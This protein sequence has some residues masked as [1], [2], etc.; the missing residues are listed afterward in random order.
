MNLSASK[1][2]IAVCLAVSAGPSF[3]QIASE[4]VS[5]E[6]EIVITAPRLSGLVVTDIPPVLELDAT[7]VESYG[8]SSITE[9]L[10][11]LGPQTGGG[12]GRGSGGPIVLLNGKRIS[13]FS[14]IRDLPPEAIERVQ[15][16][17]EEVA[18]QFGA[19][20]D[21]RVVNFILKDNFAALTGEIEQGA[22][23]AGGRRETEVESTFVRIGKLGRT[24]LNATYIDNAGLLESARGI[25][26]RPGGLSNGGDFRSLLPETR[27]L[28]LNGTLNR[29]VTDDVSVTL[30]A[31]YDLADTLSL[32]GARILSGL[33]SGPTLQRDTQSSALHGGLTLDGNLARWQWTL[34]GNHDSAIVNTRTDTERAGLGTTDTA[35]S[36]SDTSDAIY[37]LNGQVL[38]LPAGAVRTTVRVGF[39]TKRLSS[40]SLRAGLT[41]N[42]RLARDEANGR[43][44][45]SIPLA[46]SD[47][48]VAAALGDL[49]IN[50]N[51]GYRQ[52][53]DFGALTS[54]GYG[55][56]W[57]P[58]KGV[59]VLVSA[60]GEDSEPSIQELGNPVIVT[61]NV[62]TYDFARAETVSINRI[63]GGSPLLATEIRRDIKLGITVQPA[64]V[65]GLTLSAN[66]FRNRSRN[67]V[68]GF[69]TLT[70]E[71]E[72]AFPDR[73]ARDSSGRLVLIDGRSVN[74]AATRSDVLRV[75]FNFSKQFGQPQG[76][77]GE[78]G[79]RRWAGGAGRADRP[80]GGGGG[81]FRRGD[82][83]GG[84]WS[85]SLYDSI[86]FKDQIVIRPELPVLDLLGG[87]ATGGS[88]GAPRHSFE[89]EGGWFSKGLGFR[90][91]GKYESGSTVTG[92]ALTSDLF[93]SDLLTLNATAFVN[94]DN[95]K[96]LIEDVPFLKG[97]RLRLSFQ[98][99]TGATRDV[100]D[101]T[102][103]VPLSYQPGY[104]DPRGR[105]I[106]LSFR[107]RF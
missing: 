50:A 96:K 1:L 89:L 55:L 59:N 69:P 106:E 21:Q 99:F 61:P 22:S 8:A 65:E 5:E 18:L 42:T 68:A 84:R 51:F 88:G 7:A 57:T 79:R 43:V 47:R 36:K 48:D 23:L 31:S 46:N 77:L 104:L 53:S 3:A 107:K 100:R 91:T 92:G 82:G 90:F 34:T 94:F 32:Q 58:T 67:P 44:N 29:P 73:I 9:L 70:P 86:R 98:N 30:N 78:G 14:E 24:T 49:S 16:M 101:N 10:S 105:F 17:P 39:A 71:I 19:A 12:R 4:A 20:P 38:D 66:Y 33:P 72:I 64:K 41:A 76:G 27:T 13:G 28:K 83:E 81:G 35:R 103:S 37:T 6:E 93:F 26:Q 60:I 2:A 40:R 52:L 87:S 75:G 62:T 63:S 15:V 80:A 95:R 11:A 56:N 102:G 25:I 45:I 85:I 74:F 54:F 97:S